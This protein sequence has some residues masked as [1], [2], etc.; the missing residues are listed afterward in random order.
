MLNDSIIKLVSS[1]TSQIADGTIDVPLD[2]KG[3]GL[4]FGGLENYD[5]LLVLIDVEDEG[6]ATGQV[7]LFI[8]D[9]WAEGVAWDDLVASANIT[10]GTTVGEQRFVVQ[11]RLAPAII[12]GGSSSAY[13]QGSTPTQEAM[14]AASARQG[15]FGDRIRIREKVSSASGTPTGCVY[16]IY[17]I[18]CR[19]SLR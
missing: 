16:S 15:P 4:V 11:G 7:N 9:S 3:G 2:V 14:T 19:S 5:S 18:P 10:L 1:R 17:L 13:N 8:E 12:T 6:A